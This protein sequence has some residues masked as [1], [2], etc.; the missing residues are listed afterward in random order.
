MDSPLP[1]F[2]TFLSVS[3]LHRGPHRCAIDPSSRPCIHF[4]SGAN[5]VYVYA[6]F[7]VECSANTS[8]E[9]NC[10]PGFGVQLEARTLVTVDGAA[11]ELNVYS[12]LQNDI[13]VDFDMQ[14]FAWQVIVRKI[15][16]NN[17]GIG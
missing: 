8:L 12:S 10:F 6:P 9:L 7:F 4:Q 1:F 16:I 14:P 2:P 15:H 17:N 11:K 3:H 5:I 13:A